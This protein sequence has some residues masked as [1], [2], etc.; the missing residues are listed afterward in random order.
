MTGCH[1]ESQSGQ[2][3]LVSIGLPEYNV[4]GEINVERSREL[5]HRQT[6]SGM[7]IR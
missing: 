7:R 1:H 6:V 2:T 5:P 4:H 3:I